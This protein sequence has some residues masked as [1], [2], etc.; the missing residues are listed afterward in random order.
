LNS[1]EETSASEAVTEASETS[2]TAATAEEFEGETS[3]RTSTY[4]L[5]GCRMKG[6]L[7]LLKRATSNPNL[8]EAQLHLLGRQTS[9]DESAKSKR[10]NPLIAQWEQKIQ[11][12][13]QIK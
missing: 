1:L 5:Q 12:S 7:N 6:Q 4:S 11:S 3:T 9:V 8:S 10:R 2:S 13:E